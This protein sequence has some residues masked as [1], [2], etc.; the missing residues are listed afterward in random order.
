MLWRNMSDTCKICRRCC[1]PKRNLRLEKFD[2]CAIFRQCVC[3][4]GLCGAPQL[5]PLILITV[6]LSA[7]DFHLMERLCQAGY[8]SAGIHAPAHTGPTGCVCVSDE[9]VCVSMECMCAFK[10]LF[11]SLTQIA[12]FARPSI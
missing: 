6:S 2:R 9:C 11:V 12:G 7:S 10:Y 1:L 3:S 5:P 4:V 8:R